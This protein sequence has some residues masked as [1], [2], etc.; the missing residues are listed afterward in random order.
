MVATGG[1]DLAHSANAQHL[2]GRHDTSPTLP[3]AS[4]QTGA[5]GGSDFGSLALGGYRLGHLAAEHR[6]RTG[7]I[8][9]RVYGLLFILVGGL[10]WAYWRFAHTP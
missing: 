4:K 3:S 5:L 6:N 10:H 2:A 8:M 1:S 7:T 9:L